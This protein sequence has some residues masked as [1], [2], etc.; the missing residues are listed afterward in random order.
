MAILADGGAFFL[1]PTRTPVVARQKPPIEL[2]LQANDC[3]SI[4]CNLLFHSATR[5]KVARR[6]GAG[7]VAKDFLFLTYSCHMLLP[8]LM[9][10]GIDSFIVNGSTTSEGLKD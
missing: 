3:G 9:M 1:P 4:S 6:G 7:A 8:V 2:P 10:R 5:G